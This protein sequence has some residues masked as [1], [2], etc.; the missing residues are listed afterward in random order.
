MRL[1]GNLCFLIY[2]TPP[3]EK[4]CGGVFFLSGRIPILADV[5]KPVLA[6]S[7]GMVA[8]RG[9]PSGLVTILNSGN[10]D[11]RPDVGGFHG[12]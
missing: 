11:G 2:K 9:H 10:T 6:G 5:S 1:P 7:V 8:A 12:V 3:C 4:S